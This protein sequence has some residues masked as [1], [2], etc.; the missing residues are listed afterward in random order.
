MRCV[1]VSYGQVKGN[2]KHYRYYQP[3]VYEAAARKDGIMTW[4]HVEH[5]STARRSTRLAEQDARALAAD[6]G[7]MFLDGVRQNQAVA[8][9][10]TTNE[11]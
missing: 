10:T 9:P 7:V 1:T 2:A 4:R 11:G 6:L 3:A 8:I 5:R